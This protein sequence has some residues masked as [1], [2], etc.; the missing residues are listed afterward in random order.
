[1]KMIVVH[2]Y[3]LEP[4]LTDLLNYRITAFV[5]LSLTLFEV[6]KN[7]KNNNYKKDT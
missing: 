7:W 3:Y 1:M 5:N 2:L 6:P 4:S